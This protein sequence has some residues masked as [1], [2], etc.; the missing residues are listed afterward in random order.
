[1]QWCLN[2]FMRLVQLWEYSYLTLLGC[3]A[4]A[5]HAHRKERRGGA[6]LLWAL[7]PAANVGDLDASP[8]VTSIPLLCN[9]GCFGAGEES[10]AAFGQK[11]RE[12]MEKRSPISHFFHVMQRAQLSR[13]CFHRGSF[14]FRSCIWAKY[15]MKL[16]TWECGMVVTKL[17]FMSHSGSLESCPPFK[18]TITGSYRVSPY[19]ANG[20]KLIAAWLQVGTNP[21]SLLSVSLSVVTYNYIG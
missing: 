4:P 20:L 2:F 3:A 13:I 10:A 12:G 17:H 9:S 7:G 14:C 5:A 18:R 21:M 8:W 15:L 11:K 1:M 16:Y 19:S 6:H